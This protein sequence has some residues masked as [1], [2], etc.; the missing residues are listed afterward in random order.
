MTK[1]SI[2]S[3]KILDVLGTATFFTTIVIFILMAIRYVFGIG[4]IGYQKTQT[5]NAA[6]LSKKGFFIGKKIS[7]LDNES[8]YRLTVATQK[9]LRAP[10]QVKILD[11]N[12]RVINEF[13]AS[14]KTSDDEFILDKKLKMLKQQD[15]YFAL[16]LP[17]DMQKEPTK[18]TVELTNA[19]RSIQLSYHLKVF[20]IVLVSFIVLTFITPSDKKT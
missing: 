1:S 4:A 20:W 13:L 17:L 16:S 11:K 15:I 12:H 8:H 18:I 3:K 10:L 5:F 14:T 9:R 2:T 6:V 7:L 19:S